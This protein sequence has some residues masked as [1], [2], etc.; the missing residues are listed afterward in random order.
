[1]RPAAAARNHAKPLRSKNFPVC[2]AS[3]KPGS[4]QTLSRV[5]GRAIAAKPEVCAMRLV[6]LIFFMVVIF[7]FARATGFLAHVI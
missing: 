3:H 5:S 6:A 4:L 1:M 2:E 7:A